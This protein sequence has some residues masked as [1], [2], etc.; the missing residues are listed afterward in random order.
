[1]LV[2]FQTR[3]QKITL[4]R[5]QTARD[6]DNDQRAYPIALLSYGNKSSDNKT[7]YA[8][9]DDPDYVCIESNQS[10]EIMFKRFAANH[11]RFIFKRS[12]DFGNY[13]EFSDY[14][15]YPKKDLEKE[16]LEK[17]DFSFYSSDIIS[18]KA[19]LFFGY[20][21]VYD[22][23]TKKAVHIYL[24]FKSDNKV[25]NEKKCTHYADYVPW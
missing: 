21:D 19:C 17:M 7:L 2:F 18:P 13:E 12:L 9:V 25:I 23:N 20:Q 15:F 6:K 14:D 24:N 4:E 10:L 11:V 8:V 3:C 1:M 5:Y 16:N 22:A